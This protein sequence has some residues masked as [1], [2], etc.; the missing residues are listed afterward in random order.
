MKPEDLYKLKFLRE[1]VISPSGDFFAVRI[2]RV[3]KK[4]ENYSYTS[5]LLLCPLE[6]K[7]CRTFIRDKNFNTIRFSV[8]GKTIYFIEAGKE[9]KS[10]IKGIPVDG[11]E[12]FVI[13]EFEKKTPLHLFPSPDKRVI[14][15]N[16]Y[17]TPEQDVVCFEIESLPYKTENFF[18]K[19]VPFFPVVSVN[20]RTGRVKEIVPGEKR[21]GLRDVSPDGEQ[22]LCTAPE[23][24]DWKRFRF[25][26]IFIVNVK[27]GRI[28]RIKLPIKL[29]ISQVQYTKDGRGILIYGFEKPEDYR[30]K[31]GHI[32]YRSLRGSEFIKLTEGLDV[33]IGTPILDDL[34]GSRIDLLKVSDDGESVF[35]PVTENGRGNIYR[36]NIKTK[37]FTPCIT[38]DFKVL[39]FDAIK[40]RC[41]FG[42]SNPIDPC[43]IYVQKSGKS[44]PVFSPNKN[45]LKKYDLSYPE[46]ITVKG[47]G[48]DTVEGWIMKPPD[49]KK[50]K[51]YPLLVEVHGGPHACYGYSFFHEFH[52]LNAMGYA[53]FFSNPH[54]SVG[55]GED[56][57]L[58]LHRKW[59]IPDTED[60]KRFVRKLKKLSYIDGERIG[61]LGGSYGGFSTAWILSH[62]KI[63]KAGVAQRGVY[64]E[65]SFL[66]SDMGFHFIMS[67]TGGIRK[68]EDY[69]YL[70]DMSPLKYAGNI[71]VPLLIIHSTMD[72]RAPINQGEELY[73]AMKMMDKKVKFVV[74]PGETHE[75]SRHGR[76]DRR[77]ERLNQIIKWFEMYI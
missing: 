49:M 76:P 59:G 57:A 41:V 29:F 26:N 43:T 61:L 25:T 13:A 35:L 8:D 75:L 6:K 64:D 16:L 9:K 39:A 28:K 24:F 63:F 31:H 14:Y 15:T 33:Y 3:K 71:D 70:W 58:A 7:K 56:F 20:I 4:K 53:V 27:S 65:I 22:I 66:S 54:G 5:D 52:V 21:F 72:F 74:F 19:E 69:Q 62:T 36:L 73:V 51:K 18:Y 68:D 42:A 10:F 77:V 48:G 34:G 50:N 12:S 46:R 37:E 17:E 30:F 38:G 44:K 2:E 40:D 45:L 23:S 11:G 67:F 47:P 1:I 32:Y 55:Y 60:I